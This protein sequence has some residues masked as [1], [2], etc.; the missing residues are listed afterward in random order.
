MI[1]FEEFSMPSLSSDVG[2]VSYWF[3]GCQQTFTFFF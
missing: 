3:I 1:D 2:F